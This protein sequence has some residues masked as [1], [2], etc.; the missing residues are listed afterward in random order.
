MKIASLPRVQTTRLLL[1]FLLPLALGGCDRL[2]DLAQYFQ[3][4]PQYKT[5]DSE[6]AS[7][8]APAP[9]A[10]GSSLYCT[11]GRGSA[12][13]GRNW[14]DFSDTQ[15]RLTPQSRANVALPA[16]K[17]GEEMAFQAMFDLEG[18]KL[19]FCP[20][21]QGD[22][23]DKVACASIYAL[24]DDLQA[25]IKRTFDIPDA[26]RGGAITCA[27]KTENLKKL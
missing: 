6:V 8:A 2:P 10:A 14:K 11:V 18:Q 23:D 21:V 4:K 15:F 25:G 24:D 5:L 13:F 27:Y 12:K 26:V 19:L 20:V 7:L 22:P 1:A 9:A 17:G 3:P 16:K